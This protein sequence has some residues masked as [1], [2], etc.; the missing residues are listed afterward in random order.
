MSILGKF[1]ADDILKYISFSPA[2]PK[3]KKKK[4]KGF[5]SDTIGMRN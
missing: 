5:L 1:L 4:K 3:K 2:P